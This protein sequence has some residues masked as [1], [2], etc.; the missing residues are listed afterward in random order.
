MKT[1]I[2]RRDWQ[3][4][5]AFVDGQLSSRKYDRLAA[6]LEQEPALQAALEDL[7]IMKQQLQNLPKVRA[8]RNFTL[9]LE[10][11]GQRCRAVRFYNSMRLASALASIL[12]ILVF[13]GDNVSFGNL[14][15]APA[16]AMQR[17]VDDLE[18]F[19]EPQAPA[20]EAVIA[21]SEAGG[22]EAEETEA[23]AAKVVEGLNESVGDVAADKETAPEDRW[24]ST[25]GVEA[26]IPR[27]GPVSLRP[28]IILEIVLALMTVIS[29][30]MAF[31]QR[32][33]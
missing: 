20:A 3:R 17:S 31:R 18:M 28:V 8:P 29:G 27:R 25:E 21:E 5:S 30:L 4:L 26:G 7:Q 23:D 13:I 33:R 22:T 15:L 12:F 1:Q 11:V 24:E 14:A 10:M 16:P 2:S 32:R 9:T 6:R 19:A